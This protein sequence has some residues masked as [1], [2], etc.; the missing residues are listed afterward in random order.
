ML[1][2]IMRMQ[3]QIV[4]LL[5]I[6]AGPVGI[7]E[8]V[9]GMVKETV[10]VL[11]AVAPGFKVWQKIDYA[12][13]DEESIDVLLYLTEYWLARELSADDV[14]ALYEMKHAKVLQRI[15]TKIKVKA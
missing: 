2:K 11:D 4:E 12:A 8:A 7:Q 1:S 14:M 3:S 13:A 9:L 15:E 10:E 6:P 5:K